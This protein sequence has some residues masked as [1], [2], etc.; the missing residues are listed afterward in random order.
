VIL[1]LGAFAGGVGAIAR[2]SPPGAQEAPRA[3]PGPARVSAAAPEKIVTKGN[4]VPRVGT[5]PAPSGANGRRVPLAGRSPVQPENPPI[6]QNMPRLVDPNTPI[7]VKRADSII[8]AESAD[9]TSLQA[10]SLRGALWKGFSKPRGVRVIPALVGHTIALAYEAKEIV[11]VAAF[12]GLTGEWSTQLLRKPARDDLAP[13]IFGECALYQV[14]N[15][16]YA[17]SAKTGTW[18]VLAL[19]GTEK[20]DIDMTM[21]DVEVLQGNL[22]YIFSVELGKWSQ[23][24]PVKLPGSEVQPDAK[25]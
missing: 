10:M 25:P 16:F 2:W 23:A 24:T 5:A 9:G 17:F 1:V 3:D 4:N 18:G 6:M 11:D 14:E 12:S 8:L 20:P 21:D 22:L 19:T 13:I 7:P 15:D